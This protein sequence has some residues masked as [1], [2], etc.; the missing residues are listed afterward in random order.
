[1]YTYIY[2]CKSPNV[3]IG[4][5]SKRRYLLTYNIMYEVSTLSQLHR[6]IIQNL[7]TGW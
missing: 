4:N 1:M 2:Y 6:Y 3:S 5:E 7:P